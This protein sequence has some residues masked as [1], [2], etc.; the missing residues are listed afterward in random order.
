M[1][2]LFLQGEI[3]KAMLD[4]SEEDD[5]VEPIEPF[6]MSIDMSQEVEK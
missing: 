1:C 6:F 3:S 2:L 5:S 4:E